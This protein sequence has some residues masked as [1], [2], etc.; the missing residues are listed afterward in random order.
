[1]SP[2]VPFNTCPSAGAG[3]ATGGGSQPREIKS[4][5]T[6]KPGGREPQCGKGRGAGLGK[7][8]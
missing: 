2:T 3:T 6:A 7:G 1:M 4:A 8:S 5:Q